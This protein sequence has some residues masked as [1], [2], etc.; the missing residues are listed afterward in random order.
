[1]R[2]SSPEVVSVE[3]TN[4]GG[5]VTADERS[6]LGMTTYDELSMQWDLTTMSDMTTFTASISTRNTVIELPTMY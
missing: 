1:M 3:V 4:N 5:T 2:L 6:G